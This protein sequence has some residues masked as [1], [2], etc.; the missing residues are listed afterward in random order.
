MLGSV[1]ARG[2]NWLSTGTLT[3]NLPYL[4]VSSSSF[5]SQLIS[6][7][8]NS[9]KESSNKF[10][11][12]VLL[13]NAEHYGSGLNLENTTDLIFYHRMSS[14]M[15]K[16][17]LNLDKYFT[18]TG[19][20]ISP[21]ESRIHQLEQILMDVLGKGNTLICHIGDKTDKIS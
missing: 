5:G 16:Q 13:L 15:E 18:N 21:L 3:S 19:S 10:S 12:N 4:L 8:S 1:K 6:L 7:L 2:S 9:L 17:V 11:L 20:N 14:D